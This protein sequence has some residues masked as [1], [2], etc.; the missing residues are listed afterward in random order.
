MGSGPA[1]P[2]RVAIAAAMMLLAPACRTPG[3]NSPPDDPAAPAGPSVGAPNTSYEFTATTTDPD[4]DSV[5]LRFDW[6]GDTT[7][8]GSWIASGETVRMSRSWPAADTC[9]IRAQAQD[10][11]GA[12]S[13]WSAAHTVVILA[14]RPPDKPDVPSGPAFAP[15]ESLCAFAARASDP[16]GDSVSLRFSWGD[17]DTS[18]W[19]GRDTSG[20]SASATHAWA[21]TGRYEVRAQARDISGAV[22]AWSDACPVRI[23]LGAGTLR[24]R[25]AIGGYVNSSPAVG[26][27]GTVYIGSSDGYLYAVSPA[28]TLKWRH[29]T[30]GQVWSSAAVANDG[31]VYFGSNDSCLYAVNAAGALK[32]RY[33]TDGPVGSSPAIAA[34]GSVYVGSN[35]GYLYAFSPGGTLKWRYPA[36]GAVVS[37][38]AVGPDGTVFFGAE[39]CY[40]Y[41]VSPAGALAWSYRANGAIGSS[42]AIGADGTVY[43]GSIDGSVHAVSAAGTPVWQCPANCHRASPAIAADG[44]V[45]VGSIDNVVCA[46]GP[47]GSVRWRYPT[48]GYVTS[49]PA[50]AADGTVYVTSWSGHLYAV[51]PDG[52]LAWQYETGDYVAAAPALAADGTVYVASNDNYLYA[53]NGAS[54]LAGSAWPKFRHDNR[55]TGRAGGGK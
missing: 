12:L 4:G 40:L 33:Q 37:S 21:D 26:P 9:H 48:G 14:N 27:D 6:D 20:A 18:A 7:D 11:K 2:L 32:W 51:R 45:Y 28:G 39:N 23:M 54:P 50:V 53:L 52:T 44:T 36:G 43:V 8:F 25:C 49:C 30:G 17:G 35:D 42:P 10:A 38:P 41:A 55:N 19:T 46:I 31:T 34:D 15:P 22:S 1:V 3:T 47:G 13:G 29:P 24:W 5:A 16:D